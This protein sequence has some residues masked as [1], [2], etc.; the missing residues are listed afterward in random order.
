M[1]KAPVCRKSVL[2]NALAAALI[3]LESTVGLLKPLLGE[4]EYILLVALLPVVNAGLGTFTVVK[5]KRKGEAKSD[6]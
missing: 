4:W 5:K 3:A 2:I 6:E 1:A